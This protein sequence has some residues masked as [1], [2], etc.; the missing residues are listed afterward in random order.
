MEVAE[1]AFILKPNPAEISSLHSQALSL[2][3]L[4]H[5]SITVTACGTRL[6]TCVSAAGGAPALQPLWNFVLWNTELSA[7]LSCN[8]ASRNKTPCYDLGTEPPKAWLEQPDVVLKQCGK[9][10]C[11]GDG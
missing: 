6:R 4:R 9:K 7:V 8:E 5:L 10:G 2:Q 3:L 11:A 1:A